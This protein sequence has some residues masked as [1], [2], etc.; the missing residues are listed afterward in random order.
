MS[1]QTI[2]NFYY[3]VNSNMPLVYKI[4]SHF[5]TVGVD[6]ELLIRAGQNGLIRANIR[7]N[8]YEK[9]P[10]KTF[11]I[12]Y[13]VESVLR[14]YQKMNDANANHYLNSIKSVN[15]ESSLKKIAHSTKVPIENIISSNCI[16]IDK[17][18]IDLTNRLKEKQK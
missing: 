9:L 6:R 13:I 2:D 4:V 15:G 3:I 7:F 18:R 16:L 11:C 5:E 17:I 1:R 12:P 8:L 10:F 14:G